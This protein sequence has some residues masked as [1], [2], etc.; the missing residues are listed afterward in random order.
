MALS[1]GSAQEAA[2]LAR[3]A[4]VTAQAIN[5]TDRLRDRHLIVFAQKALGDSL[6]TAGD[7]AG[8]VAAWRTALAKWPNVAWGPKSLGIK[9]DLLA[10]LGQRSEA[11]AIEQQLTAMGYRKLL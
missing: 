10:R 1:S 6:A 4:I 7:K 8:A 2:A 3:Q 11:H 9:A 5:S